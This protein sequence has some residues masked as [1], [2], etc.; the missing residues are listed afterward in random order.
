MQLLIDEAVKK[1]KLK[2][3]KMKRKMKVS[4]P[5]TVFVAPR[6]VFEELPLRLLPW[7]GC[8][9]QFC[10]TAAPTNTHTHTHK[11]LSADANVCPT[12]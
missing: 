4:E 11:P 9:V 1:K 3:K 5:D 6:N 8:S 2:K 10:S 7:D 12:D